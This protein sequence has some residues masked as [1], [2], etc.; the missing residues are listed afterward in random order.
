MLAMP[1]MFSATRPLLRC[2]EQEVVDV[3]D[4]RGSPASSGDVAFAEIG[5]GPDA[6]AFGDHGRLADL[7]GAGDAT[8]QIF[9]RLAFVKN[10]LAVQADEVDGVERDALA[11]AGFADGVGA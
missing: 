8:A 11:A 2:A 10:G 5:N 4:K 7:Q 9:D 6:G 1:P 3:G